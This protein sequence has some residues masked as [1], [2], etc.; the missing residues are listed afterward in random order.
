MCSVFFAYTISFS[1]ATVFR[2]YTTFPFFLATQF[3][4]FF[5]YIIS[6]FF[7]Y[8]MSVFFSYRISVFFSYNFSVSLSYTFL[9]SLSIFSFFYMSSFPLFIC[10]PF[11]FLYVY[12][13]WARFRNH[14]FYCKNDHTTPRYNFVVCV[15]AAKLFPVELTVIFCSY[16]F[17]VFS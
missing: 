9:F 14:V 7:S 6:V 4:F 12:G 15:L 17:S 2:F 16:K 8:R 5:S 1:L 10:R 3:P 11:V 13:L